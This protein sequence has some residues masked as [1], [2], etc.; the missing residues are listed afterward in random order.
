MV[1]I[2]SGSYSVRQYTTIWCEFMCHLCANV[3]SM[4]VLE[5]LLYFVYEMKASFG[6]LCGSFES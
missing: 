4:S 1:L 3:G 2:S 5:M 6:L